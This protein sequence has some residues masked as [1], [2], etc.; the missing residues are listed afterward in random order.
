MRPGA[1]AHTVTVAGLRTRPAKEAQQVRPG[2]ASFQGSAGRLLARRE[3]DQERRRAPGRRGLQFQAAT[4]GSGATCL[5][6][7]DSVEDVQGYVDST[8]ADA[9]ENV[10]YEVDAEQGFARQ[11]LGLAESARIAS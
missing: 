7:A 8:L 10:C 11:P 3:P 1:G 2:A 4:D 6:E 9:S 5:W